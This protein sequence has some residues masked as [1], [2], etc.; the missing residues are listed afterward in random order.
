MFFRAD[1]VGRQHV[2]PGDTAPALVEGPGEG[3]AKV[4]VAK[5]GV[6]D[7]GDPAYAREHQPL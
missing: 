2:A 4:R 7:Q 5:Q 1:H 3:G 6:P